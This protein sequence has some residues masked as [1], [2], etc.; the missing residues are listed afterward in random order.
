VS[1]YPFSA[2]KLNGE[3]ISLESY[4]GQVCLIVNTTS[5]CGFTPQYE[6]LQELYNRYKSQGFTILAFPCNQFGSQELGNSSDI[7]QFCQ[8]NYGVTF[9]VFEKV[10]VKGKEMHPLFNYLIQESSGILS[11][12][13]K[14]NFTK[15]LI[16][17]QGNVVKRYAPITKPKKIAKE[18]EKY[19]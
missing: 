16:D 14:W 1:I 11:D 8:L 2:K 7:Q 17:R 18:I 3:L 19:L 15:F 10:E 4:Q 6:E 5:K 9:P 13:I 12:D